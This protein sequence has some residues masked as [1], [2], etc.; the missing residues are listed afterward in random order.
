MSTMTLRKMQ[1]PA[2]IHAANRG[3]SQ[4]FKSRF[5]SRV[6]PATV[7]PCQYGPREVAILL[8]SSVLFITQVRRKVRRIKPSVDIA[9]EPED[10][11]G[12]HPPSQGTKAQVASAGRMGHGNAGGSEGGSR[13]SKRRT[14]ETD[15]AFL[16]VP[17]C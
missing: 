9:M 12:T 2:Q 13:E 14:S 5:E 17:S 3:Q 6:S 16:I 10:S 11:W 7:K 15:S 4:E 8:S 1:W